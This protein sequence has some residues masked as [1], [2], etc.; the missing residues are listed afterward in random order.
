MVD[1]NGM[2]GRTVQRVA[3]SPGFARVAP[4][5]VPP[6][7]RFLSRIT[8]GRLVLSQALV[9]SLVLTTTGRRS[10]Q[11]RAAPLACLPDDDGSFLVVGSNFGRQHHPAWTFN[12]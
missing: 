10:G 6:V 9:P 11:P 1:V 3:G 12:L 8:G 5:V 2:I 7:D 4:R